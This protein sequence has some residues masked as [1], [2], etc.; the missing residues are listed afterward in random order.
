MIRSKPTILMLLI[1][2]S[3]W[4]VMW[5]SNT[6]F[7]PTTNILRP[8]SFFNFCF[9]KYVT[10]WNLMTSVAI[11]AQVLILFM[12]NR[13]PTS[14]SFC[15]M[16]CNRDRILFG[17]QFFPSHDQVPTVYTLCLDP[18]VFHR[19]GKSILHKQN[20]YLCSNSNWSHQ[21]PSRD[22]FSEAKIK[23]GNWA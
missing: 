13:F 21:I 11:T 17:S 1:S 15:S 20:K 6:T 16:G 9:R 22:V 4:I 3:G 19:G 18:D 8:I 23:K 12:V 14:L 5:C 2:I 10:R 7:F